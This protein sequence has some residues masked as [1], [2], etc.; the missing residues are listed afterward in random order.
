[1]SLTIGFGFNMCSS[2]TEERLR[3]ALQ[4]NRGSYTI[5]KDGRVELNLSDEK[6][7]KAIKKQIENIE[8]IEEVTDK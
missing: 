7:T 5:S 6:V 2:N 3:K 1:M 8:H 4:E